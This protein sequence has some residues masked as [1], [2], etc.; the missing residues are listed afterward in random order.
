MNLSSFDLVIRQRVWIGV[1][2]LILSLNFASETRAEVPVPFDNSW[3]EQGFLRLFTNDYSLRGR[4]L[5][6][7]SDGT[8]SLLWRPAND[9]MHGASSAKWVWRV[10]EGV[11]AT[12]LTA[13]GNDDRNISVYFVFVDSDRL[14]ALKGRSARRILSEDSARALI[15][16][17]GGQHEVGSMLPSPYSPRLRTKV[18]R[19]VEPGQFRE[20]VDLENDY[21]AA[22][23]ERPGV[24]VGLAVSADS[25]DT[26]GRIIASIGDLVLD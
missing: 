1:A 20:S 12:D 2:A 6:V 18:L 13:K 7:L 17:W 4:Q 25:D 5:D 24:L 22:F 16:V 14:E 11:I 9:A 21:R 23:G 8:V 3:R 10:R 15:Y 26:N 19:S